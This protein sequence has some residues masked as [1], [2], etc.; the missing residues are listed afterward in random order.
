VGRLSCRLVTSRVVA[1]LF[2]WVVSDLG[3]YP[4]PGLVQRVEPR[5]RTV[6][7]LAQ[8]GFCGH[9]IQSRYTRSLALGRL[10]DSVPVNAS[11]RKRSGLKENLLPHGRPFSALD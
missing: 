5:V 9:L 1:E 7:I 11:P 3:L 4:T 10:L 6:Y 2:G 8:F